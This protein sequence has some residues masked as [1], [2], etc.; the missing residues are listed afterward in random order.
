MMLQNRISRKEL[1]QG[2]S[3]IL[4]FEPP[5]RRDH[6]YVAA[7]SVTRN[8]LNPPF[9]PIHPHTQRTTFN[10]SF[11]PLLPMTAPKQARQV[12]KRKTPPT[13]RAHTYIHTCMHTQ[14]SKQASKPIHPR[15]NRTS[16][17]AY[18]HANT[19]PAMH[20]SP[21]QSCGHPF[22]VG[23]ENNDLSPG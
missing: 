23:R 7:C 15:C 19:H 8:T 6:D 16:K 13:P 14:R 10:V 9:S 22:R 11:E 5:K 1:S 18:M 4:H 3:T 17:S 21:I 2:I 20:P 12:L